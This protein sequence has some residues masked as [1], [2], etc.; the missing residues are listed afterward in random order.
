M[1]RY[2][3]RDGQPDTEAF[4]EEA[5]HLATGYG[6]ADASG[7]PDTDSL[8]I[9]FRH[10][11]KSFQIAH[12]TKT[13][14]QDFWVNLL[15]RRIQ[16][17]T[18]HALRDVSFGLEKGQTIGLIGSNGAGKSTILK[19]ITRIIEPD[20]GHIR[21]T[22]RTSA[23]LELGTGFHP[24]LSGRD[25]I[26]LNGAIYGFSRKEIER[27][28][29]KIVEFS[30]LGDFIDVPVKTLS[31]GM[32]M[33]LAFATS[34]TVDPD[35]LIIDEV[36][37]VGDAAFARKCM[38]ELAG[39]KR[40]GKSILIVSHDI[41]TMA[42]FCD[43]IVYL[44]KGQVVATGDPTEVIDRYLIATTGL[45]FTGENNVMV[46]TP[47]GEPILTGATSGAT[48]SSWREITGEMTVITSK[49]APQKAQQTDHEA[50]LPDG[51]RILFPGAISGV[52]STPGATMPATH[53]YIA[54]GNTLPAF[55]EYISLFNPGESAA[56]VAVTICFNTNVP[57]SQ[58]L[59]GKPIAVSHEGQDA[60]RI[61]TTATP[62]QIVADAGAPV[63]KHFQVAAGSVTTFKVNDELAGE[64]RQT[65]FVIDADRPIVAERAIYLSAEVT[66]GFGTYSVAAHSQPAPAWYFASLPTVDAVD[67]YLELFN[68]NA[69][70]AQVTITWHSPH[71]SQN[72]SYVLD[73]LTRLSISVRK[74]VGYVGY[75]AATVRADPPI[76]A[77][78]IAYVNGRIGALDRGL[79]TSNEI[80]GQI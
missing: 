65:A 71:G 79:A 51:A 46:A 28:Y 30:G 56:E 48:A 75:I 61:P 50:A 37:A 60:P 64:E 70:P 5:R 54:S 23:M 38:N 13:S 57:D 77:E 78:K 7:D 17:Q 80:R 68:P 25:N 27:R 44:N 16:R 24:E 41:A 74:A 15:R 34:I 3:R 11:S 14:V 45:P 9:D 26:F 53:W 72:Q 63:V 67:S 49:D 59:N 52:Q 47:T 42:R 33:R 6:A 43:E 31:S 76:V 19:L 55:A 62:T 58:A 39:F 1:L 18:F 40:R 22:G 21:V 29:P 32:Y 66:Y 73:P 2:R 12:E 35:I 4:I 36:L 10:V 20:S 8:A 69:Q